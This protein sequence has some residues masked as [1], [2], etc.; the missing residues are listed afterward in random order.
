VNPILTLDIVGLT[1]TIDCPPQPVRALLEAGFAAMAVR[2]APE[3]PSFAY[4]IDHA[5]DG[6][7]YTV[8]R[9]DGGVRQLAATP[10]EAVLLLESDLTL[11]LQRRR[12]DLCFLHAAAVERGGRAYLLA[13]E[14]GAG[15][16]TTTWGL[17]Q[18]GFRYLTDELSALD[19]AT[20]L[21]H[22]YPYALSFK[23]PPPDGYP[24]PEGSVELG[25]LVHLPTRCLPAP[26][27]QQPAP[28]AGALLIRFDA[29]RSAP[30]LRRLSA[31][32]AGA[33]LY[34]AI[35]NALSHGGQGLDAAIVLAGRVPCFALD[36]ADLR[37]T[38][39]MVERAVDDGLFEPRPSR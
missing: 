6:A 15:K 33:H 9:R 14:S 24:L 13:A 31:S 1:I 29:A 8:A 12:S 23:T 37:A 22:P 18:H 28:V 36:A 21:V 11:E 4:G 10:A 32:E 5:P 2:R 39:A 16:T 34:V 19:L 20:M 25:R 27:L 3:R 17:L 38:C 35:L 7:G 26:P 30:Q